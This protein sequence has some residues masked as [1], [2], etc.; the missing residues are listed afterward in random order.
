MSITVRRVALEEWT[1]LRQVRLAAMLDSPSAFGSTYERE[2]SFTEDRWRERIERSPWWLA[3]LG[4]QPVGIIA[5]FT[6]EPES[7]PADRH[8]VSM[9]VDPVARRQ[10]VARILLDTVASWSLGDGADT[11]SLWVADGNEPA[12]R[13]YESY[14]FSLTGDQAP[15]PS[16]PDRCEH[17]MTMA[18][19]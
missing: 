19:R 3:W 2:L 8:V 12:V 11:L 14:G 9:W 6:A 13:L 15:M 7:A 16:N 1:V 17:Y 4:E 5:A 18:L 10:G